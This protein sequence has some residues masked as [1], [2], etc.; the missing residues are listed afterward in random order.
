MVAAGP[1]SKAERRLA[2]TMARETARFERKSIEAG[3]KLGFRLMQSVIL[4]YRRGD[5]AILEVVPKR[6]DRMVP[7]LRDLMVVSFLTGLQVPL[8][9]LALSVHTKAISFL[10]RRLDISVAL[11]RELSRKFELQAVQVLTKA[12]DLTEAKLQETFLEITRKGEHVREGV[13]ALH[14]TFKDVGIT[15][16]SS[17]QLEAIFRTQT[18]IAYSVGR[19]QTLQDPDIQEILWGYKYVTVGDDRVRDNHVGLEGTTLPKEDT[20]WD[21]HW[22]PNGW[23][24]RCRI[25][26]IYESRDS[27]RP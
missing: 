1:V 27:V 3:T 4:A 22:T 10:R 12:S 8:P 17:F 7:E 15:P 23:A 6:F 14:K 20:F 13:K 26:P 16:V 25:I 19:W 18:Q 24:C 9:S 11:L 2:N 5:P 21:V